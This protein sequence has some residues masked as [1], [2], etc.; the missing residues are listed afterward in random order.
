MNN[1]TNNKSANLL[2]D[3][4]NYKKGFYVSGINVSVVGELY[5]TVGGVDKDIYETIDGTDY[6]IGQAILPPF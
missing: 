1:L 2:Q 5:E 3:L 4:D 6:D